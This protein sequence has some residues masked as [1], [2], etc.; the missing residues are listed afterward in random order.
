MGSAS[1][2]WVKTLYIEPGSP[3]EN[4]Y[5]ESFNG[6]LRRELLSTEILDT[7]REAQVLV[8]IS[9]FLPDSDL[10]YYEKL[11]ERAIRQFAEALD[12]QA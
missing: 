7:L 1:I 11:E 4:R 12:K 9:E 2:P 10:A 8:D 6:E 3:W 5:L